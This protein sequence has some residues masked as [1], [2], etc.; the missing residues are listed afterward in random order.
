M[1]QIYQIYTY[2]IHVSNI[3]LSNPLF[4]IGIRKMV[5][6]GELLE[7]TSVVQEDSWISKCWCSKQLAKH[8]VWKRIFI[9]QSFYQIKL[10]ITSKNIFIL[11]KPYRY[12]KIDLCS[13]IDQKSYRW[14]EKRQDFLEKFRI[15]FFCK[16]CIL[17]QRQ[18]FST[19][20]CVSKCK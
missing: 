17:G 19:K 3:M 11:G 8:E 9:K 18:G 10:E 13:S 7:K 1:Y 20:K 6:W 15:L 2:I 14:V 12:S 4:L 5:K 16:K